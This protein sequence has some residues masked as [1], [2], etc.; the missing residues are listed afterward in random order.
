MDK[1]P[2]KYS[3]ITIFPE[4]IEHYAGAS[5]L[6]RGQ[7][8][9]AIKIEAL[10]LRDYTELRHNQVDDTPYGGGAGMVLMA[11]PI[12]KAVETLVGP[13]DR[14]PTNTQVILMD[15][16]GEPLT[17]KIARE[18]SQL[19][20]LVII[21]GR[22]EGIDERVREHLVDRTISVGPYVLS[23]GEL[24]A[25]TVIEATARLVPGVLGKEE[26]LVQ[27]SHGTDETLEYPHYT[28]PADF[29]GY[30]VPDVLQSGDH[31]KIAA[32]RKQ[33]SQKKSAR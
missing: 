5:I 22:Y 21:C 9:G 3:V 30:K 23:G 20:H 8:A 16:R 4:V 7:K 27:E 2:K 13:R 28:K 17:Q 19:D 6:G 18:L 24:P 32:W 33:H 26:S 25:L 12:Y 1:T 29:R 31:A 14:R 11:P 15:P 10:N